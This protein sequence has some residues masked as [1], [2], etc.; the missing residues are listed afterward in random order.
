M[1]T[2]YETIRARETSR[3]RGGTILTPT[4]PLDSL[5]RTAALVQA[6]VLKCAA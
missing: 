5:N 2:V 4:G 6:G 3:E 1:N